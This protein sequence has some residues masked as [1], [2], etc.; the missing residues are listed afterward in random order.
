MP[1]Q[2]LAPPTIDEIVADIKDFERKYGVSTL[3]FLKVDGDIDSVDEDDAI[4]WL[5]RVEQFRTLQSRNSPT[6]TERATSVGEC[7]SV[8]DAMEK[9]AA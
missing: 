7:I 9:L 1:V 3:D 8:S 4:E 5:Y 6:R 2:Q